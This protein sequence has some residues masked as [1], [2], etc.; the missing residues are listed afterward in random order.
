[1]TLRVVL[2]EDSLIVRE[3]VQLLLAL[4]PDVDVVAA[5]A[6][7]PALREAI[8]RDGPDV[9]LTDIRMPPI[10][11][12]EGIRSP[13]SCARRHP[14]IGVVVLSQYAEPE[15]ALGAARARLGP[16]APTCSRSACTTAPSCC[17]RSRRRRRRLVHRPEDR[18][19]ARRAQGRAPSARRSTS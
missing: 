18:R 15:Y 19:G 12:D 17:R 7:L 2:G 13:T 8:E 9:V 14:E 4:D 10:E 16:A 6:D 11:T 3:G 1:M 5:C